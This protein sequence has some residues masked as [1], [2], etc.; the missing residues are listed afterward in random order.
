MKRRRTNSK[1]KPSGT[2]SVYEKVQLLLKQGRDIVLLA[3]GELD[4]DS[5]ESAKNAGIQAIQDNFTRY[6]T[7]DGIPELRQAIAGQLSNKTGQSFEIRNIL[8]ANGCKQATFNILISILNRG[9]EVIIPSPY[10]TS[11]PIQVEL[12]GG[13][14]VFVKTSEQNDFQVNKKSLEKAVTSKTR[15]LL[16]TSPQNPTGAVYSRESL[17]VIADFVVKKDLWLLSDEIYSDIVYAPHRFDSILALFP[18]LKN[19]VFVLNGFSKSFAMTGWRI[20]Y[21][22]GPEE[23]IALASNVHA[24]TTSN[25]SSISQKAALA[26][27]RLEPEYYKTFMRELTQKRDFA[28]DFLISIKGLKCNQPKGAFYLFAN[29]KEFI[30]RRFNSEVLKSSSQIA[31]YLLSEHGVAFVPGEAFG[32]PGFI[33]I[34]FAVDM[35][36]LKKGLERI[37]KGLEYLK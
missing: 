27:L 17:E 6:T 11:H 21:A 2:I 8:V 18:K 26:A 3:V 4:V 36:T 37:K 12:A 19:R 28:F 24:N 30:G 10:Y 5:P 31:E 9:D 14:P 33:R 35:K 1:I 20:G 23:V 25:V 22:A 34:S 29:V 32:A 16:I 15:A 13:K 7:T